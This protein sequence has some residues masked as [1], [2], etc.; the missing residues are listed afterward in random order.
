MPP[1]ANCSTPRTVRRLPTSAPLYLPTILPC[2]RQPSSASSRM[3]LAAS[4][5]SIQRCPSLIAKRRSNGSKPSRRP[6]WPDSGRM[7]VRSDGT[8]SALRWLLCL[9]ATVRARPHCPGGRRQSA[10]GYAERQALQY[11]STGNDTYAGRR[12][13]GLQRSYQFAR[14]RHPALSGHGTKAATRSSV[15]NG[16]LRLSRPPKGRP[17][18]VDL[19][20]QSSRMK[21][22]Y[23]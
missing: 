5:R 16:L 19:A 15:V 18:C 21:L 10:W 11:S 9:L 4:Q 2:C 20:I 7:S 1:S 17:Q 3:C 6:H 22:L 12:Y 8:H 23:A 14:Y 13:A